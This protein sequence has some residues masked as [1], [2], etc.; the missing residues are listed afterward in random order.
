VRILLA[1]LLLLAGIELLASE[2]NEIDS[3]D[4]TLQRVWFGD[5]FVRDR[6]DKK[7][8]LT[9]EPLGVDNITRKPTRGGTLGYFLTPNHLLF[10]QLKGSN[11]R[12]EFQYVK[13][14]GDRI[15]PDV[16][17]TT[18]K[19]TTNQV[20][21]KDALEK[22]HTIIDLG[23]PMAREISAFYEMEKNEILR[24]IKRGSK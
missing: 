10:I 4:S 24:Y 8:Q 19:Y 21:I 17:M 9:I 14:P 2:P 20:W 3:F 6:L 22:G 15:P 1:L 11:G 23:N 13:K 12:E 18:L 7:V 5:S 16:V